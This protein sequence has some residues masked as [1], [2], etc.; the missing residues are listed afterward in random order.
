M[1]TEARRLAAEDSDPPPL[2]VSVL[3]GEHVVRCWE[4]RCWAALEPATG[5]A[6]YDDVLREWPRGRTRDG[7]LYLARLAMACANAGEFDRARTEGRK[8]LAIARTTKSH[9]AARELKQLSATL[10]A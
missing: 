3:L 2:S 4:A 1:L 10:N 6:L 5:V 7:G 9:V 8:A